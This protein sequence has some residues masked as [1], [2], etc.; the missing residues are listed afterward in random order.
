MSV[1]HV[2]SIRGSWD[3][4]SFQETL[5]LGCPRSVWPLPPGHVGGGLW[6]GSSS[7]DWVT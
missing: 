7:P 1:T 5:V 3:N 2:M 6:V 4:V